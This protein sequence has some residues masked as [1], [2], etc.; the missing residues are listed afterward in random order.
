MPFAVALVVFACALCAVDLMLTL[1]VVRRLRDH[2]TRI[3][4]LYAAVA[5][6]LEAKQENNA[7]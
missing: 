3:D 4:A 6:E 1:A 2:T 7:V 5:G